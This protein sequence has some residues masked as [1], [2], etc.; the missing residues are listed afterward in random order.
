MGNHIDRHVVGI[1]TH[2]RPMI[3]IKSTKEYLFRFSTALM[4]TN[5]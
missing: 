1:Q 4:L 3:T 2:I 5:E